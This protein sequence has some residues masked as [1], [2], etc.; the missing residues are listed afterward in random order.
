MNVS[1]LVV[2]SENVK[3]GIILGYNF[4]KKNE[5]VIDPKRKLLRKMDGS[6]YLKFYLGSLER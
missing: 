6:G 1:F 3:Y 2:D 5:V 4:L